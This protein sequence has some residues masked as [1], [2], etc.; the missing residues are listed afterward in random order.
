MVLLPE[1]MVWGVGVGQWKECHRQA[2]A[3]GNTRREIAP[4]GTRRFQICKCEHAR[5]LELERTLVESI[6][7]GSQCVWQQMRWEGEWRRPK[8]HQASE[9]AMLSNSNVPFTPLT[10]MA[11]WLLQ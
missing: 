7:K 1:G 10:P 4:G 8:A 3:V 5:A 9:V 2:N 11:P 6:C